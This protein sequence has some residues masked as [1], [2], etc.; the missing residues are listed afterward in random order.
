MATK[1]FSYYNEHN[2]IVFRGSESE[3]ALRYKEANSGRQL[4]LGRVVPDDA[5]DAPTLRPTLRP[6][7]AVKESRPKGFTLTPS[8]VQPLST[9]EAEDKP[10]SPG[11]A[12]VPDVNVEPRF[13]WTR[14]QGVSEVA[15]ERIKTQQEWLGEIGMTGAPPVFAPGM[16]VNGIGRKNIRF[17]R[18]KHE[19]MPLIEDSASQLRERV[20]SE[21][22]SDIVVNL[23]DLEMLPDGTITRGGGAL[24]LEHRSLG[25]LTSLCR[26]DPE[27]AFPW[28]RRKALEGDEEGNAPYEGT[29]LP[30]ASAL[31]MQLPPDE[32]ADLFN[33]QLKRSKDRTMVLRTRKCVGDGPSRSIFAAVSERY[34]QIDAD[35]LAH[36][37][38]DVMAGKGYR[39]HM[40]YD[41]ETTAMS[42]EATMHA[43][44]VVDFAAGDVFKVGWAFRSS[45]DGGSS[46]WGNPVAYRNL[47]LNLIIIDRKKGDRIQVMH[48]GQMSPAE[49]AERLENSM[50]VTERVF[51]RFANEWNVLRNT[52]ISKVQLWGHSFDSV[53]SALTWAVEDGKIS[54]G[55][56]NE[57]LVELLLKGHSHEPGDSLADFINAVTRTAHEAKWKNADAERELE[58][59]AGRE[60]VPVLVRAAESAPK[61]FAIS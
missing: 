7:P 3:C 1:K 51:D 8:K 27:Q 39:G 24:A 30:R 9:A 42:L 59:L 56:S 2:V 23:S 20:Q 36:V 46:V 55:R 40:A 18:M 21:E 6:T 58:A 47:C 5:T 17:S 45:D 37:F 54:A 61:Q 52:A 44:G 35:V 60:L 49:V 12:A 53:Q 13:A 25:Q 34:Q 11:R 38:R 31:L 50:R 48:K 33:R 15:A 26:W 32:R 22:R 19:K 29:P 41:A 57:V 16:V 28:L 4:W 10:L 14:S 43:D